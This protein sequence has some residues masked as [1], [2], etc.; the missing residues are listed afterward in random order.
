MEYISCNVVEHFVGLGVQEIVGELFRLQP[1]TPLN[2]SDL[3]R[4]E[5]AAWRGQS[6]ETSIGFIDFSSF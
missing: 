3:A 1:G 6:G 5:K 2:F 4:T